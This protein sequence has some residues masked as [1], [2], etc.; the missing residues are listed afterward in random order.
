MREEKDLL[1]LEADEIERERNNMLTREPDT[2][3]VVSVQ[4]FVPKRENLQP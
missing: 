4:N 2:K 3:S 1:R